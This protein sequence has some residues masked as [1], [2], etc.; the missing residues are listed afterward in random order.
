ME[1]SEIKRRMQTGELYFCNDEDLMKEQVARLDKV[2]AYNQLPPNKY[3][4]K[5][6]LL[7]ELFAAIGE[8]CYIETPFY[9]NWGGKHVRFGKGVYANFGLTLVDDGAIEVGDYVLFAPHVTLATASHPIHPELRAHQAQYNLPIRIGNNVWLGTG[10]AVMP[11]VT[12]G[13]NTVV[14]AGSVVTRD[15]PANVVAAGVPCRVLRPIT[16]DDRRQYDHG[17]PINLTLE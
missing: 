11:G 5:Q 2:F 14:G 8:D 12:I 9:A 1:L 16:D 17:R 15:L 7:K 4:E 3:A 13:D 10:C 6:A